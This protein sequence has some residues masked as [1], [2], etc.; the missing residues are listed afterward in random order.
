[1]KGHR[2]YGILSIVLAFSLTVSCV[3]IVDIELDSTYSRL[4]VYGTITTDSIHHQ[5]ELTS[6][7]DY[8]YNEAAPPIEN[9]DVFISFDDK[10]IQLVAS[11]EK[12]N[13]YLFPEAFRGKPGTQYD[14]LI[15][16]VDIDQDGITETYSASTTMP[17]IVDP[18][19]ITIDKFISPFFSGYQVAVWSPD[20]PA[21]NF[22]NFKL[23]KNSYLINQR[24]SDYTV[25]PDDLFSDNYIPGLPVGFLDDDNENEAVFPGDTITLEVNSITRSYYNFIIEAQNEIFGN[26]P[27]FSGPP[28]NVSTNIENGAVGI[29]TAYSIGRASKIVPVPSLPQ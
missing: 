6:T 2:P 20:P 7:T 19:S 5:V 27:L 16:N 10:T 13:I 24:I 21:V 25:Q 8:F 28:A 1:M 9:A 22:Y 3:E 26:N 12:S 23:W 11:E 17:G 15:E 14:L 18:D 4:V 29:F